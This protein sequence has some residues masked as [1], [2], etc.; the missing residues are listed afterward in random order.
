M[1]VYHNDFRNATLALIKAAL[2]RLLD[3]FGGVECGDEDGRFHWNASLMMDDQED[4]DAFLSRNA[5]LIPY[6][7]MA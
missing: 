2:Q 3:K 6:R 5:S 4:L 1:V 7:L